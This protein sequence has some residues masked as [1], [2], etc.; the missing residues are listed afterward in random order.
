VTGTSV[1]GAPPLR[2]A[3]FGTSLTAG[4]HWPEAT[5]AAL[6]RCLDRPVTLIRVARPGA[7][8]AWGLAE[9][10]RVAA[11]APDIV[12]IEF[13]INDADL[14]DGIGLEA[15]AA[16]HRAILAALAQARPEARLV[17]MTMSPA[18]RLRGLLRPGLARHYAAYR[19]LAAET[20]AGLVDLYPRWRALPQAARGLA[21]GLHPTDAAAQAV[22]LPVLV[23]YLARLAGGACS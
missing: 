20:G 5:A 9:T 3:V 1:T 8:S 11:A 7:G 4:S 13:A 19:A 6:E 15:S 21:D 16:N 22:I 10:A 23:P 12:L 18:E 14:R 17:L 2:L